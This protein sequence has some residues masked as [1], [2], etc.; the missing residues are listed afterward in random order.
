MATRHQVRQCIVSLLY[1][2]DMGTQTAEFKNEFLEEKKIR[3]KQKEFTE[4]LFKGILANLNMLDEMLNEKL[5]EHKLD[6]IGVVERAIL[7]LGAYEIK[8]TDTDDAVVINEAIELAKEMGSETAPKFV[9]GVLDA[10]RAK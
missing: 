8:F 1:A 9:N 3:N 4:D 7:R 2:R 5:S 10:L 6:D